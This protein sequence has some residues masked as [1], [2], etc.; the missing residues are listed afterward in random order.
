MMALRGTSPVGIGLI[1]GWTNWLGAFAGFALAAFYG[2]G[3]SDP[4]PQPEEGSV[5]H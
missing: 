2:G 4:Q 1:L 5:A 3:R